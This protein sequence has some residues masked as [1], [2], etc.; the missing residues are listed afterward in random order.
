MQEKLNGNWHNEKLNKKLL[1]EKKN[2]SRHHEKLNRTTGETEQESTSGK[3]ERKLHKEKLNRNILKEK[4]N[5]NV[6]PISFCSFLPLF[7][8][9]YCFQKGLDDAGLCYFQSIHITLIWRQ[10]TVW[11][12]WR[13]WLRHWPIKFSITDC[14][15]WDISW[16]SRSLSRQT[17]G[18]TMI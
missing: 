5:L 8:I 16:L 12:F 4:L 15:H 10:S 3:T 11:C 13:C 1:R 2:R 9:F 6:I 18:Y 7:Q 14:R 17:F